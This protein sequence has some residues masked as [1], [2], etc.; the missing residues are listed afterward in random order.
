MLV[1]E[2]MAGRFVARHERDECA[3]AAKRRADRSSE[4][5]RRSGGGG[6]SSG[7]EGDDAGEIGGE[8]G[9]RRAGRVGDVDGAEEDV[10]GGSAC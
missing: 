2:G 10:R 6:G 3:A 5:N 1:D 7:R 8:D 4:A 9:L